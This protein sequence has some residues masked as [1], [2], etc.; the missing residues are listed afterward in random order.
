MRKDVRRPTVVDLCCGHGLTGILFAIFEREVNE[1]VLVDTRRPKSHD[2]II[3]AVSEVAPWAPKKLKY[4]ERSIRGFTPSLS[5]GLVGVHACGGRTDSCLNMAVEHQ[6]PIAVMPCCHA[7][8]KYGGRS[9]PF[10]RCVSPDLAIDIDRSYRLRDAGF[11][12]KW[13]AI[14]RAVTA[15]NRIIVAEPSVSLP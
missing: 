7:F 13:N 8:V 3:D 9:L 15:K 12:V 2:S 10:H 1:V 6:L 11:S 4:V 5:S 14:P